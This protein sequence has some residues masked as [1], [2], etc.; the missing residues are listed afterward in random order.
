MEI[1]IDTYIQSPIF[2]PDATRG[3][4]RF[5]TTDQLKQTGTKG[6]VVNT[7]HLWTLI[8]HEKIAHLGGIK[9]FMNWDGLVL[10]DSG[11][12]QVFSLIHQNRWEGKVTQNGAVFKAPHDGKKY[13][14]TPEMSIDVQ[15]ALGSD[16]LVALD[17]CRAAHISRRDAQESVENTTMWGERCKKHFEKAY[18]GRKKTGKL[19]FGVV[20][21]ANHLDLREKSSMELVKIGFD[22]YNFGGY[23]VDDA[24]KLVEEE[25]KVMVAKTP[26][27]KPKYAMGVGKP[28]DII[29]CAKLGFQIFDTVLVTRNARHGTL[30][31]FDIPEKD[32]YALRIKNAQYSMDQTPVDSTCDCE[33][34]KNYSKAY[35]HSLIKFNEPTA[36]TLMSI[37]NLTFYQRLIKKI[38]TEK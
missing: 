9:N 16:I 33:C 20:Q 27:D 38:V 3:A 13:E 14:L 12:F 22:G 31:S 34:C 6:I 2:L 1:K 24:G 36:L 23:V 11:G 8:G 30:Y 21:G 4:V 28:Q 29:Q 37:H 35:L 32:G 17:D 18:G 5:L 26:L 7:L 10:S 25:M 15:M 19:L